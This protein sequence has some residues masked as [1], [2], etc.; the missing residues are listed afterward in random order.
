MERGQWGKR[1]IS[2]RDS[3]ILKNV[4]ENTKREN[5]EELKETRSAK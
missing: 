2:G 4:A 1:N 3:S 5:R